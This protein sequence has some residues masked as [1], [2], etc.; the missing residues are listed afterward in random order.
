M[1]SNG[2]NI[3]NNSKKNQYSKRQAS[4]IGLWEASNDQRTTKHMNPQER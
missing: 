2:I 1:E 4:K 3:F